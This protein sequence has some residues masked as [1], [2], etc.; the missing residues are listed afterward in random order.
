VGYLACVGHAGVLRRSVSARCYIT[1]G[2]LFT[3]L[4]YHFSA[5]AGVVFEKLVPHQLKLTGLGE[6]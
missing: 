1:N 2:S 5:A 3:Q 4:F 6:A